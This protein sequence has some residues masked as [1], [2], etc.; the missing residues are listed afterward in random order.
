[1]QKSGVVSSEDNIIHEIMKIE[2]ISDE[3]LFRLIIIAKNMLRQGK[4][5]DQSSERVKRQEVQDESQ[6]DI[7]NKKVYEIY[8]K[9]ENYQEEVTQEVVQKE[10]MKKEE[11][12]EEF[13]VRY[14]TIMLEEGSR[15]EFEG[16]MI[17]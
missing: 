6:E 15:K 12:D 7:N 13:G 2:D 17:G 1:M 3:E 16:Q 11:S 8:S 9:D 5:V 14:E 4:A 10:D